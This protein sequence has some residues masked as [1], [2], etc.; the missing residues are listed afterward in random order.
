LIKKRKKGQDAWDKKKK[1]IFPKKVGIAPT[2]GKGK[3]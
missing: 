2:K 3:S 1:I